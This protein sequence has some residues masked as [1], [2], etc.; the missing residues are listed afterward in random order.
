MRESL[1]FGDWRQEH[2][3]YSATSPEGK[4]INNHAVGIDGC[5]G[6]IGWHADFHTLNH[7]QFPHYILSVAVSVNPM[8][9]SSLRK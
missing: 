9:G 2:E 1:A 6:S 4:I 7:L 5:I 3:E 8:K